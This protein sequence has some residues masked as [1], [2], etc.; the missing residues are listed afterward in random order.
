MYLVFFLV[1]V[2]LVSKKVI[3]ILYMCLKEN[4]HDK[5]KLFFVLEKHVIEAISIAFCNCK[6]RL[7]LFAD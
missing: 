2:C 3:I 1:F 6:V 7:V 4:S 5:K